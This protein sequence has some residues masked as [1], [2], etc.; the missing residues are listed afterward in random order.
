METNTNIDS[1][2]LG[3]LLKSYYQGKLSGRELQ[4]VENLKDQDEFLSDAMEGYDEFPEAIN[5]LLR[6]NL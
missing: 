6:Y 4:E 1:K 3:E 2:S 5:E